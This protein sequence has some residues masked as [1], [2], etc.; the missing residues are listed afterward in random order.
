M[1]KIYDYDL[2]QEKL[3]T[4]VDHVPFKWQDFAESVIQWNYLAGN[5][6]HNYGDE[7]YENQLRLIREEFKEALDEIASGNI[8]K[9]KS[10]LIDLVVVSCYGMFLQGCET[11]TKNPFYGR[12]LSACAPLIMD[13]PHPREA[14]QWAVTTLELL[15]DFEQE[16]INVLQK[17]DSK[18]PLVGDFLEAA[19]GSEWALDEYDDNPQGCPLEEAIRLQIARLEN[20]SNG[21]Y[22]GFHAK[23]IDFEGNHY[24][25]F[26]D[27][28][29]KIMKN[30]CFYSF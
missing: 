29:G 14:F 12:S 26:K 17:N 20:D 19:V 5:L 8:E 13:F 2:L 1:E 10:E 21:R 28:N 25:V 23:T 4:M 9:L 27:S 30:Y 15:G 6:S 24:I 18:I 22:T 11:F 3:N 16:A 7:K